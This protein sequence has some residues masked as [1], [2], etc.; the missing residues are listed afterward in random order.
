MLNFGG[1]VRGYR[2]EL[3]LG[4]DVL[5]RI[6]RQEVAASREGH[7]SGIGVEGSRVWGLGFRV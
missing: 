4:I 7:C 5:L 1:W 3:G 2:F 6:D